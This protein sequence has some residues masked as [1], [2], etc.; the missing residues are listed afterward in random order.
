[1]AQRN[2]QNARLNE[3]EMI[4]KIRRRF[5]AVPKG[6]VGVGDDAAVLPL[7]GSLVTSVDAVIE[8]VHFRRDFAPLDV[9][10]AR[11]LEAAASDLAAMGARFRAALLSFELPPSI[12][13]E[14]LDAILEGFGAAAQTHGAAIVGGN[15]ARGERLA[16]HTTVLGEAS[17]GPLFRD[18]VEPGN[19]LYVT[20]PTGAAAL[21]L[22]LLLEKEPGRAPGLVESFLKPR[23]RFD[24]SESLVGKASAAIDI[25]DGLLL[26]L[27]RMLGRAGLGAVLQTAALPAHPEETRLGLGADDLLEVRLS[28]GESYELLIAGDSARL[29]GVDGLMHIGEV[30]PSPGIELIGSRGAPI[31][32][33]G[34]EGHLHF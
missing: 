22:R 28:G 17:G 26:D 23:A 30:K 5:G 12:S 33:H 9:L 34:P 4:A 3:E 8:G 18:S 25:S 24:I 21:G 19:A 16:F 7:S 2:S 29:D 20:G 13:E 1:M 15:L 11:A 27:E 31:E 10:A 6:T 32:Y 14:E